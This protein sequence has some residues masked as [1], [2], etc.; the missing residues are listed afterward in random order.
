MICFDDWREQVG[1]ADYR[2]KDLGAPKLKNKTVITRASRMKAPDVPDAAKWLSGAGSN[3]PSFSET[4]LGLGDLGTMKF[5]RKGL[6]KYNYTGG[7][8]ASNTKLDPGGD[9]RG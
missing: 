2:V 1:L 3:R 8:S 5:K 6:P 7:D 4:K 9:H